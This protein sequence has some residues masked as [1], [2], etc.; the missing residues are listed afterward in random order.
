MGAW[1]GVGWGEVVEGL[2]G[3]IV[4]QAQWAL[5]QM[6]HP[7]RSINTAVQG[8]RGCCYRW[9]RNP[10]TPGFLPLGGR[11]LITLLIVF[12]PYSDLQANHT[13]LTSIKWQRAPL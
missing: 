11:S 5:S 8:R 10:E 4:N 1:G 13:S 9:P 2:V 7:E 12:Q 6:T 3:G